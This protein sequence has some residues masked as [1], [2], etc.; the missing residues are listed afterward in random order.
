MLECPQH[1]LPGSLAARPQ[2]WGAQELRCRAGPAQVVPIMYM[3]LLLRTDTAGARLRGRPQP[4]ALL[5][6]LRCAR[7]LR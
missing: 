5:G 3:H 1:P 4:P 6:V 2:G 7:L